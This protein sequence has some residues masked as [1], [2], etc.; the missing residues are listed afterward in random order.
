MLSA[1]CRVGMTKM[2]LLH[3][4]PQTRLNL[5]VVAAGIPPRRSLRLRAKAAKSLLAT[6]W[7][8]GL[9]HYAHLKAA[10][11]FG[12][13]NNLS[14]PTIQLLLGLPPPQPKHDPWRDAPCDLHEAHNWWD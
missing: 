5:L 10:Q 12:G 11:E 14:P 4:A 13:L 2:L 1:P 3:G 6:S 7:T 8:R 9:S